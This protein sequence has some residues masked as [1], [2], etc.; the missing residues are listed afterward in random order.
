MREGKDGLFGMRPLFG[1]QPNQLTWF[2]RIAIHNLSLETYVL[3]A[4]VET[5]SLQS[6]P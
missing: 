5:L 2:R 6:I 4:L 1:T 3:L